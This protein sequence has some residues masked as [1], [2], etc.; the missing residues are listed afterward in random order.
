[1]IVKIPTVMT[2]ALIALLAWVTITQPYN[3]SPPIRSDGAG[4]H[5]W[6]YGF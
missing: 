5:V 1:M 2:A 3:N 4:Y 6:V